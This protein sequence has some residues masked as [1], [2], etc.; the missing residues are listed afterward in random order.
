MRFKSHSLSGP[1]GQA[2]QRRRFLRTLAAGTALSVLDAALPAWALQDLPAARTGT[3]PELRG[4]VFDL[5]LAETRVDF[6]GR[7]GIATTVNG[8]LPGPTL[9]MR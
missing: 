8:S 3:A 9:R 4:P 6:D 2:L 7:T 5:T 1:S